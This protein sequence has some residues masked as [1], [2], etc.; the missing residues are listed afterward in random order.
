MQMEQ[1]YHDPLDS[2]TDREQIVHLFEQFLHVAQPG[3]LR[4]LAIKGNSGTGKTFLISY[5]TTLVCPGLGWKTGQL[6]F[7]QS[8]P[9]FRAILA[10]L[11]A[12]LKGCVPHQSL[13]Q[14]RDKRDEY[15]RS[16]DEY[17]ATITIHQSVEANDQSSIV[18]SINQSVQVNAQLRERELHLRAELMLVTAI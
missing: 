1:I 18:S 9:D 17:R 4:L 5:L 3:Q 14:Y 10:G 11:E 7:A 13:K 6:S 15:H 8:L 16:F 12:A 2:F